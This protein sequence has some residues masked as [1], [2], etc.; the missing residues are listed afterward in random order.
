MR[1]LKDNNLKRQ[2]DNYELVTFGHGQKR[3][4]GEEIAPRSRRDR[5]EMRRRVLEISS[6]VT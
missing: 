1:F 3:C 5:A 6:A 2:S 4:V